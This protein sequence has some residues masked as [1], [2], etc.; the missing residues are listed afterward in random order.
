MIDEDLIPQLWSYMILQFAVVTHNAA[1][2]KLIMINLYLKF[3][4]NSLLNSR[5][6]GIETF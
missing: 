1:F 3:P 4:L 6:S 5:K 2:F